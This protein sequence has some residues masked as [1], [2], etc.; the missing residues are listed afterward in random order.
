MTQDC[1]HLKSISTI[2]NI[3]RAYT[4]G[5]QCSR[6][7]PSDNEPDETYC[8]IIWQ[9]VF[10]STPC[11]GY[12]HHVSTSLEQHTAVQKPEERNGPKGPEYNPEQGAEVA[13]A[14]WFG[15]G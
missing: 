3:N 12:R 2:H 11:F 4:G 9:L 13:A 6:P 7:L 8:T 5:C 14:L 1:A 10:F 15:N